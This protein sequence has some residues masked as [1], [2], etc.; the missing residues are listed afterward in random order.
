MAEDKKPRP[1]KEEAVWRYCASAGCPCDPAEEF[2]SGRCTSTSSR[3]PSWAIFSCTDCSLASSLSAGNQPLT[4][5]PSAKKMA[6][7]SEERRVGK[8]SRYRC[9]REQ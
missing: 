1:G 9:A 5:E 3:P 4:R 6:G 8:E 7:R 2:A